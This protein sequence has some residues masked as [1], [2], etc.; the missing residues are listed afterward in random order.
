[1]SPIDPNYRPPC[2]GKDRMFF[3]RESER[4]LIALAKAHC[5]ECPIAVECLLIAMAREGKVSSSMRFG[6]WGGKT[7]RE[8]ARMA[9]RGTLAAVG[10]REVGGLQHAHQGIRRVG[11]AGA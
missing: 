7:P 9:R 2:A 10:A 11:A 4:V 6:V 3:A 8:R 5:R 1:M